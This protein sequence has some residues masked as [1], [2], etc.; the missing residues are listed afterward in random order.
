MTGGIVTTGASRSPEQFSETQ[1][2][3]QPTE[4]IKRTSAV[5]WESEPPANIQL[6]AKNV[7]Q[8]SPTQIKPPHSSNT[9]P[10][11]PT[12]VST[13]RRNLTPKRPLKTMLKVMDPSV[14]QMGLNRNRL[15]P[16]EENSDNDDINSDHVIP[17]ST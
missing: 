1:D 4:R 16:N 12:K 15:N 9:A 17:K 5:T 7:F 8:Q 2:E 13:V 3:N 11:A 14:F 6:A 10:T